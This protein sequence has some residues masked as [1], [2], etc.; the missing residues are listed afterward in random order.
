MKKNIP[1]ELDRIADKVLGYK[2]PEKAKA[3]KQ[4]QKRK[5]QRAG[6]KR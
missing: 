4:R 5:R 1:I 3:T 2:P 6:K